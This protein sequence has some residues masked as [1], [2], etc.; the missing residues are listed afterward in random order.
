MPTK[1]C[2]CKAL[3]IFSRFCLPKVPW[4]SGCQR[5]S[6]TKRML[7]MALEK[8][9]V[10]MRYLFPC[11]DH[12]HRHIVAYNMCWT[13][14]SMFSS[15]WLFKAI[16]FNKNTVCIMTDSCRRHCCDFISFLVYFLCKLSIYLFSF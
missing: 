14:S 3:C 13:C 15:S 12:L 10:C 1:N 7:D 8:R 5:S 2:S 6:C 16:I 11:S 4:I 9:Y